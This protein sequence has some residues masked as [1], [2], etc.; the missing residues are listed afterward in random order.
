[1]HRSAFTYLTRSPYPPLSRWV[2]SVWFARGTLPVD[3]ERIAPTGS[4]V[5]GIVLGAPPTQT[6]R[7]G[8]GDPHTALTGRRLTFST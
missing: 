6:P 8:A 2:E 5:L 3:S 1:M 7:N 4:T